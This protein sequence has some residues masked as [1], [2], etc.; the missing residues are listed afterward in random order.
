MTNVYT[1]DF[2]DL[3]RPGVR[4]SAAR[5]VPQMAEWYYEASGQPEALP[6]VLDVGCGEGWWAR[7][8]VEGGFANMAVGA[9]GNW[10]GAAIRDADR[11]GLHFGTINLAIVEPQPAYSYDIAL[12]LEVAEHL[13]NPDDLLAYL[14]TTAPV[15]FFSAAIPGQ[16]GADHISCRWQHEWAATFEDAGWFTSDRLRRRIWTDPEIEWWYRQNLFAAWD[17]A[18]VSLNVAAEPIL[19]MVH[20]E[21][22]AVR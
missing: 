11:P 20:P 9:D 3:I 2:Y 13:P 8:W 15:C 21:H 12:C 19:S 5:L 6:A 18:A 16:P 22:W 10:G 4:R 7:E 14:R 1:A 17:P